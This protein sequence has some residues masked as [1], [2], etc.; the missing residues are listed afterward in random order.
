MRSVLSSASPFLSASARPADPRRGGERSASESCLCR[1][2]LES[3]RGGDKSASES[4]R[5]LFDSAGFRGGDRS[6][7]ESCRCRCE[8]A[9]FRGGDRSASE[10]C[11]C[12]CE[13]AGFRG[14]DRSASESC[15]FLLAVAAI[16]LRG[17]DADWRGGDKSL[18]G[19]GCGAARGG[20]RSSSLPGAATLLPPRTGAAVL[21]P[22]RG[23]E[24]SLSPPSAASGC[25]DV[26]GG[27]R[28]FAGEGNKS[29]SSS[30]L[31][32]SLITCALPAVAGA[33]NA[34]LGG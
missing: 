5:C 28:S 31:P 33:R 17:G 23:G 13:L 26:R 24:R 32:S 2:D 14:G 15:R 6:A 4:C 25:R 1:F 8:F 30:P 21:C 20:D 9:G 12:R 22:P 10:S 27:D 11:R 29:A 7:S 3:F 34:F 16:P 18:S 19:F